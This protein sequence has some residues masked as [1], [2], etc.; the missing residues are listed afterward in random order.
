MHAG[1]KSEREEAEEVE[2]EKTY[3]QGKHML[4]PV[5]KAR[6]VDRTM[7]KLTGKDPDQPKESLENI[8]ERTSKHT[9]CWRQGE[10][11]LSCSRRGSRI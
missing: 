10:V 11:A 3:L 5:R 1:R 4:A 9:I 2:L 8:L 6:R 7:L